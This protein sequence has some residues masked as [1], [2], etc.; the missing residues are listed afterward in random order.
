M[1]RGSMMMDR[2]RLVGLMIVIG[3]LF[4]MIGAIFVD[5]SRTNPPGVETPEAR[6]ARL[7]RATVWGPMAAHIGMFLFVIGLIS[8]AVFF[9]NLDV[10]VRLFL[11]ILSFL[12]VLLILAGSTTIFGVP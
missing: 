4:L 10:F 5:W 2:R 8:A 12:A 1:M 9:E 3:L 6:A 11:V 7:D